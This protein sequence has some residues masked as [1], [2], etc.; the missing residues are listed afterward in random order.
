MGA[1][2]PRAAAAW[3]RVLRWSAGV[4]VCASMLSCG[5]S[6]GDALAPSPPPPPPTVSNVANVV[7]DAGPS[8]VSVNTLFTTITLCVPGSTT[9]CQTIDHIQI[10]TASYGLRILSEV[11]TLSLPV[12]AAT[13]GNALLECTQFADGFSWGP[14]EQADVQI[15]GESAASAAIQVIGDPRYTMVPANC[16]G[17]GPPENTVAAFGANGILGIGV[18]AQDCGPACV[19]GTGPLVYYSC[20]TLA[21]Q[22]TTVALASQVSNP[23][24]LFATDN[25]GSI[26]DLPSV[27]SAGALSVSGSLIFG[28]DTQSNNASGSETVLTVDPDFG[29]L[30]AVFNG[31]SLS[32]SFIDAGSNGNYF[33]SNIPSCA[34]T[35][36]SGFYCPPNSLNLTATL[37]GTNGMSE[38]VNFTVANAQ[39]MFTNNPTFTALPQLG[40]TN[41]MAG[42]FDFG[43]PFYYG[44]RVFTALESQATMVGTGP[45]IAF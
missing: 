32:Q 43:L 9:E 14:V 10:D 37:Q 33:D 45:Y 17:T 5:G 27:A 11:L 35:G 4:A 15:A 19:A 26:L 21:C 36:L 20:T 41:P 8:N 39:V 34:A 31:Q 25:N 40:G 13:N 24:G 29:Y 18:F 1:R 6:E 7:V 38:V 23:V 42:S 2:Q 12:Q 28:I 44:R 16:S 22:P 3:L 30:T